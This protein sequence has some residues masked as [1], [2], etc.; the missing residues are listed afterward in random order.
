MKSRGKVSNKGVIF[1]D[2]QGD[3]E[4]ERLDQDSIPN[5]GDRVAFLHRRIMSWRK[6][7]LITNAVRG[8][9]H[10]YNYIDDQGLKDGV[11]LTPLWSTFLHDSD[12]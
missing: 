11:D 3:Y 4:D 5:R 7:T 2:S 9:P 1:N 8:R 6:V 10:Y 12:E